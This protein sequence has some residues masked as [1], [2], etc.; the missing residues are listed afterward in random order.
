MTAHAL[1]QSRPRPGR[2]RTPEHDQK[3]LAAVV[4]LVDQ[5]KPITVNA[6]VAESGVSRAALYRRWPSITELI[7]TALDRGRASLHFDQ[8]LPTYE[9]LAE[10]LFGNPLSAH[11]AQYT[12]RRFRKRIQLVMESP[13]L[14]QAY[15]HS[16]ISRRRRA[17]AQL[18][19]RGVDR[20]ELQAELNVDAAID[21]INGVFYYQ[22]VVRGASLEAPE[23]MQRCRAAFDIVWGGLKV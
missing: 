4:H 19:Q 11:G 7:A 3:I 20:G 8:D 16:H 6:V 22:S 9:A 15:W 21:A 18:L 17:M 12:D 14:Q 1:Q 2:P 5:G 23:T 13:E 10:V